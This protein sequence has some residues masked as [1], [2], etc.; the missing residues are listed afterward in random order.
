[1]E[2]ISIIKKVEGAT[3]SNTHKSWHVS[4]N[5]ETIQELFKIFKGKA[6]LDTTAVFKKKEENPTSNNKQITIKSEESISNISNRAKVEQKDTLVHKLKT[7]N[8]NKTVFEV[9]KENFKV[10]KIFLEIID[11]RK[12]ILR[13]P[14]SKE[15]IAKMKTIPYYFWDKE[16]KHWSFPYSQNI[17]EEIY[18]YFS[19][20]NYQI[21]IFRKACTHA[22]IIKRATVHT[23]RHSFATHLL[24]R[25]TDLRY[26]QELL[27]HSSSKTTEIYTHITH[28]G[29]EQLKSP[30][31]NL[32]F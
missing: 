16:K 29:M 14:F 1:M 7:E 9:N 31:D 32:E 30:L 5:S 15:H 11:C 18:H 27:G 12:I 20:F 2:L 4:D 19:K 26:I 3:F 17:K 21:Q 24:E 6:L 22:K 25:G 10:K 23:L 8:L 28:K 13:F